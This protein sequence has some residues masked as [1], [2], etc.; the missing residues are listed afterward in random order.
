MYTACTIASYNICIILMLFRTSGK[1]C[2]TI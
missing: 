1:A 2:M